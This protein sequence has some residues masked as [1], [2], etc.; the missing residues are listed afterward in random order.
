MPLSI[1]FCQKVCELEIVILKLICVGPNECAG[2]V[3]DIVVMASH[4]RDTQTDIA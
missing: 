2:R 3:G 1:V 4:Y